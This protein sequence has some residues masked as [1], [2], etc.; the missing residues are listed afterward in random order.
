MIGNLLDWWSEMRTSD[1]RER[2][3]LRSRRAI[4]SIRRDTERMRRER[5]RNPYSRG[6]GGGDGG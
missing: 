4:R 2:V 3:E 5:D 1:E 6:G